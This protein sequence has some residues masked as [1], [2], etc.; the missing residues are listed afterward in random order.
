MGSELF[1]VLVPLLQQR[2]KVYRFSF[3][4]LMVLPVFVFH[5]FLLFNP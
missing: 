5:F 2:G 3:A 4:T 1:L